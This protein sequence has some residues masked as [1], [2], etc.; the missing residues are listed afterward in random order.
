MTREVSDIIIVVIAVLVMF[1]GMP[2]LFLHY[3]AKASRQRALSARDEEL[4]EETRKAVGQ[5]SER[6]ATLERIVADDDLQRG[7][8]TEL[9]RTRRP[10]DDQR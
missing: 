4:L 2:W 8:A 3:G 10:Q 1:I 7:K 5:L 9:T 6:A